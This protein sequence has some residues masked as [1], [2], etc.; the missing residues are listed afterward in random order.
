[1]IIDD[2]RGMRMALAGILEY[3]GYHVVIAED[4]YKGIEAAKKTDFKVAFIDVRMPG[5]DGFDTHKELKK[6][7]PDTNVIMMTGLDVE[8][9]LDKAISQGAFTCISKPFDGAEL[10]R[11]VV[12][13]IGKQEKENEQS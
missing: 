2:E 3:S 8:Y 1:M 11:L 5:I 7:S 10:L 12:R 6:I 13:A 9:Y 4:G